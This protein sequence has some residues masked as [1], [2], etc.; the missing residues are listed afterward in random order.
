MGKSDRTPVLTSHA[1]EDRPFRKPLP[2][3]PTIS[4]VMPEQL[5][6]LPPAH[7]LRARQIPHIPDRVNI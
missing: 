7:I 2:P 1:G 5:N 3:E 6:T 4:N